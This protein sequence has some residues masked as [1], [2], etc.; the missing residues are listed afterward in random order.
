MA[1]NWTD[2]QVKAFTRFGHNILVSAGAG[3]GKTAVLSERVYRHVGE[4]KI[5]IDRLLILT[6][7]N[8][9]AAEMKKRIRDA[10]TAD[11]E[12]LFDSE[13]EKARQINKIDSAYIM[14][15]DAYAQS[16][17]KKYHYLF[18]IDRSVTV[19]D[20]NILNIKTREI[21]NEIFL[22][23]YRAKDPSFIRLISDFCIKKDDAIR[24][25]VLDIHNGLDRIY[26]R[27]GYVDSYAES[28]YS[29]NALDETLQKYVEVLQSLISKIHTGMIALSDEDIDTE[30]MFNNDVP[31]YESRTYSEIK[32]SA[33]A[34]EPSGKSLPKGSSDK[35]KDLNSD[36]KDL[37][38]KLKDMTNLSEEE[39]KQELLNTKESSLCLLNLAQELKN[40]IDDF[41]KSNNMFSF[42]DIFRMSIDLV[43]GNEEI[44]KE[45]SD[46][47]EEILIDEYQ[48]TN[49]LQEEFINRIAHDNVY[50]VGDIKQSIYR[51]RN[52]NPSLFMRKYETYTKDDNSNELIELSR[53]Y[54]SRKEVLEDINAVFDR[55]MD[56]R[57]GGADYRR[58]HHMI[59]GR[60]NEKNRND[61][62]HME[63][64]RYVY[65]KKE[66]PFN[67]YSK[68]EAEVFVVAKDILNKIEQKFFVRDNIKN[69]DGSKETVFRPAEY[70]DFCI[71]VDRKTN[72]DLY[73]QILSFF[74]IPVAIERDE[75][76]SGSDLSIA[77]KAV[78]VL[79]SCI[80]ENRI[81]EDF[82]HSFAS[83]ARSFLVEMKDSELYDVVKNDGYESTEL[84]QKLSLMQADI[85]SKTIADIL[86]GIIDAF[87]VYN[88]V[89][90]IG[91]VKENLVK[92]DY[93]Y[94]LAHNL[95]AAGYDYKDF[96][97]YL[98]N[99]FDPKEDSD[100]TFNIDND[101]ENAVKI[102]N[103]H[104]SK[105]LEYKICYFIGLDVKFNKEEVKDRISFRKDL[106]IVLPSMVE[107]RGL[108][109]TIKKEIF[110]YEFNRED[111]SEK[112]R[113][114]YVALTRTEEK[115]IMVCPL[116]DKTEGNV[117]SK[118]IVPDLTRLGFKSFKDMLDSVFQDISEYVRDLDWS[119]YNFTKD[120]QTKK[121]D[122]FANID[123][124][125]SE[126]ISLIEF[127]KVEPEKIDRSSFS[128][129]SG[130][131]SSDTLKK[132]ELGTKLHYYLET[133][134]FND[135]DY[136]LI[137]PQYREYI[138]SFMDS[139]LMKDVKNGKAYKEYEFIYEENNE[140]KHGFIDLLMEYDDH[141]DIIDYK[142][143]NID[144]EHYDEQLNGYRRYIESI[145]DKK[146]NCYL[147]SLLDKSY[148]MIYSKTQKQQ[149]VFRKETVR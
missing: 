146:T 52:A 128:K 24:D 91:E 50:M 112:L 16:L 46:G 77:I 135:P 34:V 107:G 71:I 51:F 129:D 148:R 118:E 64:Y 149:N 82:R 90:K 73:K 101:E 126:T 36:I 137:E 35:A 14:T 60:E 85:E 139:D 92:I 57:I 123:K 69:P 79:L 6:F 109:D 81:D 127:E 59:S 125:E 76:M 7:T 106:G 114:L 122:L 40:R 74:N 25:A 63:I 66:A 31:L 115:M 99:V 97:E 62:Q 88:K 43:S 94:Q 141:F 13:E 119:E 1:I 28:F 75:N 68:H 142:T 132:M 49:D 117:S 9:A 18:N 130:L 2:E 44:R 41:K 8:K 84:Y 29:D 21:L 87:D 5:D 20:S 98:T 58:S 124:N 131:I 33:F 93:L 10:I 104:K 80:K 32:E 17:V 133:L 110:R 113:L 54:R 38:K 147:Y 53:N 45:I 83:L 105:G 121:V 11:I 39:L 86:D 120:Y 103:I 47:F 37:I 70:R 138:E 78:F 23:K 65:D 3:S 4:R 30:E 96:S 26:D 22:E 136:S 116:E 145:S 42:S 108:K 134:D 140:K 61:D 144:D 27:K 48:D 15:F 12:K 100:V 55:L 56:S 143:K 89:N 19:I 102:I 111:I 72:F 67:E 95:N